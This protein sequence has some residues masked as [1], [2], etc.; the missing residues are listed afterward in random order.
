MTL[1]LWP[2][3]ILIILHN[4]CVAIQESTKFDQ[5]SEK[6]DKKNEWGQTKNGPTT[7]KLWPWPILIILHDI[8]FAIKK[9]IFFRGI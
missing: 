5:K 4:I 1:K 2:W 6:I 8:C 9:I 3:P 7:P